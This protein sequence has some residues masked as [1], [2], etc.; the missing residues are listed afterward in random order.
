LKKLLEEESPKSLV[1]IG[2]PT[3]TRTWDQGIMSP[4]L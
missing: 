2:G 4:L 1:L 3:R